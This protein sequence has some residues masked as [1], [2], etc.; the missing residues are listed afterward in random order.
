[1]ADTQTLY[2]HGTLAALVPGLFTGT[3]TAQELLTH[4]DTG[5]GTLAGLDGELIIE[6]GVIYQVNHNGTVRTVTDNEEVPFA[7]VHFADFG[8]TQSIQAGDYAH[9]RSLLTKQLA[10][11]NVFTA[12]RLHGT[13]AKVKTRAVRKQEA[14]YPTLVATAADQSE[15][16]ALTVTG[17]IS[18]YFSPQ[19]YAGAA[20]PG[21]HLHF[22]SDDHTFGGHVLDVQGTDGQLQMQQFSDFNLHLPVA[23]KPFMRQDFTSKQITADIEQAEH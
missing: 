15:F 11:L 13:F 1:M 21:F 3:M 9:L 19:L 4:G 6:R 7:N 22:L 20:A 18:G 5:I 12:I 17:T 2:Q 16:S 23:S 8:A 14:P 10:S